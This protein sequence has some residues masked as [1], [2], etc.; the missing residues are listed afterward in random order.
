MGGIDGDHMGRRNEA[1]LPLPVAKCQQRSGGSWDSSP[2]PA[3]S[4]SPG[5]LLPEQGKPVETKVRD[6]SYNS[7]KFPGSLKITHYAK[8]LD[9]L[10]LMEKDN[11]CQEQMTEMFVLQ[12][13]ILKQP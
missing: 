4:R 11:L 10:K 3:V 6:R 8:Y 12:G 5:H 1:V 7:Q 2:H 13:K 9:D